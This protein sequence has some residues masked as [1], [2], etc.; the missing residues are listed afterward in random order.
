MSTASTY[1]G[2]KFDKYRCFN[3]AAA[4]FPCIVL[5]LPVP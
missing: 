3:A 1:S 4:H 2:D 5:G